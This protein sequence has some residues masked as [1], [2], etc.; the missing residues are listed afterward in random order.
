MIIGIIQARL[1][2]TRLPKKVLAP[3]AGRSL[4]QHVIERS[5]A[6]KSIDRIVVAT[7]DLPEDDALERVVRDE[8]GTDVFRGAENDVLDRFYRCAVGYS[9]DIIV[10]ITADDPL[11]DGEVIDRAVGELRADPSLDYVSN[12]LK[13]TFPEG[14]DIE[15]FR[16]AALERAA[17]EAH[18]PSEREHV[19]PFIWKNGDLFRARNFEHDEDLSAWR[20]TVDKPEDLALMREIFGALGAHGNLFSYREVIALLKRRPELLAINSGTIRNEGYE[21]SLKEDKR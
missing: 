21:R 16:F 18:L 6:A 14:L 1:G 4:I 8:L 19:T 2:S 9:P 11:K 12:T 13:P 15:T 3:I 20:L 10:R 7:T 5:K 17:R